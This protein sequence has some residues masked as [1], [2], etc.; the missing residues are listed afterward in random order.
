METDSTQETADTDTYIM[1]LAVIQYQG[2]HVEDDS[3]L[4]GSIAIAGP[5]ESVWES[6]TIPTI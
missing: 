3:V 1:G 5:R 6:I 4:M 2:T